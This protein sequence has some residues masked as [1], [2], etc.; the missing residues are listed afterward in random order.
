MRYS[1]ILL[2]TFLLMALGMSYLRDPVRLALDPKDPSHDLMVMIQHDA[3]LGRAIEQADK[4]DV[5]ELTTWI[6]RADPIAR[7]RLALLLHALIR[8]R[9]YPSYADA[10]A[11]AYRYRH[12]FRA[13]VNVG[14]GEEHIDTLIDNDVAYILATGTAVPSEQEKTLAKSLVTRLRRAA[15]EA[16]DPAIFD[17]IGCVQFA[18]KDFSGAKESFTTAARLARESREA[19]AREVMPLYEKRLAAATANAATVQHASE[20]PLRSLPTE[21]EALPKPVEAATPDGKPVGKSGD[22]SDANSLPRGSK[23]EL[24]PDSKPGTD[25]KAETK[26]TPEEP[27]PASHD[28]GAEPAS[29]DTAKPSSTASSASSIT[30]PAEVASP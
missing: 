21:D 9:D 14:T 1:L 18:D 17:T 23:T 16:G 19:G 28:S 12:R 3:V 29:G 20:E 25:F 8:P 2:V 10:A 22:T 5:S 6:N 11:A 4:G 15:I 24:K 26:S 27:A 30:A 13:F 7:Q